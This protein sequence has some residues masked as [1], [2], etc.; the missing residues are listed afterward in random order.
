MMLT[1]A[2]YLGWSACTGSQNCH[3]YPF[4]ILVLKAKS[5]AA[6]QLYL[7]PSPQES[8]VFALY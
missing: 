5:V 3:I 6:I 7:P 8:K 4:G 1:V 2:R